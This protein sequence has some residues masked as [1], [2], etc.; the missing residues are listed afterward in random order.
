MDPIQWS[1]GLAK[2]INFRPFRSQD[3]VPRNIYIPVICIKTSTVINQPSNDEHMSACNRSHTS[4]HYHGKS[5]LAVE[6]GVYTLKEAPRY[7]CFSE[8]TLR[9][10]VARRNGSKTMRV[11]TMERDLAANKRRRIMDAN[12]E[13]LSLLL[14]VKPVRTDEQLAMDDAREQNRIKHLSII[15]WVTE[16]NAVVFPDAPSLVQ[17]DTNQPYSV[18]KWL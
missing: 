15:E 5:L 12:K 2:L 14:S 16:V 6:H 3:L 4:L 7:Y 10:A 1:V 9:Q 8:I 11:R 18:N 13:N 17:Q